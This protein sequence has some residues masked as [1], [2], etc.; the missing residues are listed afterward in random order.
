MCVQI[1]IAE[2]EHFSSVVLE[3]IKT[4]TGTF[5]I[6]EI[7][8]FLSKIRI[9]KIKASSDDKK[10]IVFKIHDDFTGAEPQIGFSIK[11]YIGSKPTL[12]NAGS[13]DNKSSNINY[14]EIYV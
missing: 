11:S 8:P 13:R 5:E 7:E 1:P 2:F 14:L 9:T 3:A 6:P 10:D 12:L 4:G